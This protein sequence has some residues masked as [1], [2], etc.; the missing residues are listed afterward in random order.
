MVCH[1][2]SEAS[3]QA[4]ETVYKGILKDEDSISVANVWSIEKEE[5]LPHDLQHANIKT[6]TDAHLIGIKKRYKWY[7]HEMQ[8]GDTAKSLLIEMAQQHGA[9]V[10]VTGY[11]GR[12]GE[13]LDP[14]I[15]GTAIQ[16]MSVNAPI[17]TL[18]IK[19]PHT[20]ESKPNG[21][22]YAVC[23]D[24]SQESLKALHMACNLHS[25]QDHITVIICEQ[26]NI[27]S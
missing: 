9:D 22:R 8:P 20:R 2:G 27:D 14:T 25:G 5:Y 7:D 21:Y 12:K 19:D 4:L 11:H 17:P 26:D 16:Y 6:M 10:L 15:M 3:K 13:K 24:G 1:D 18:I 23:V